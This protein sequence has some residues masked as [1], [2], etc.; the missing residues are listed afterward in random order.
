VKRQSYQYPRK[1]FVKHFAA[2]AALGIGLLFHSASFAQS[3]IEPND[4]CEGAQI[5]DVED[6]D[7]PYT[8]AG[9]LAESDRSADFFRFTT[10]PGLELTVEMKGSATDSGTLSDPFLGLFGSDCE[11]LEINDDFDS[12]NSRI[13]FEVP[14]DGTFTLAASSCCDAEFDG[15]GSSIGTYTLI[16]APPPLSVES[17]SARAVD[18]LTGAALTGD[19]PAF[20]YIN[21]SRC[22]GDDCSAFVNGTSTDGEGRVRFE[23]DFRDGRLTPGTYQLTAFATEYGEVSS[24]VFVVGEGENYDAGELPLDPPPLGV[25]D[26]VPCEVDPLEGG[27]C[28]YSATVSNNTDQRIRG[29]A[30]SI[31]NGDFGSELGYTNFEASAARNAPRN[32]YYSKRDRI[33]LRPFQSA[34]VEFQFRVPPVVDTDGGFCADLF[35]GSDPHPLTDTLKKSFLFCADVG[36]TTP[37]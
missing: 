1:H 26:I 9:D 3:E 8:L 11:L 19:A 24:D 23:R 16:V 13:D 30:W 21:L 32:G 2:L 28:R 18:A 12:L 4:T 10:T 34:V 6:T 5:V 25:S 15:S 20:A 27:T 37:E 35:V 22:N 29:T 36:L 7:L 33:T 31:V 14:V 17:I